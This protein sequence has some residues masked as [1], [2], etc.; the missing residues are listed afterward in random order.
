[1]WTKGGAI[2]AIFMVVAATRAARRSD[3]QPGYVN[4]DLLVSSQQVADQLAATTVRLIDVRS[5]AHYAAGHLPGAVNLPLAVLTQDR[6]GIPGMVAPVATIEHALGTRGIS[7]QTRVVIYDA[8]G[9]VQATRLFWVLDYLGHPR[10][11]ILQGGY[12][13][14]QR[15]GRPVARET[16]S[17]RVTRYRARKDTTRLANLRWVQAQ[18]Q[19]PDVVLLDSRSPAEFSGQ[20]PG[21]QIARPGH[22]PGAVNVNWV[23]NLTA[24]PRRFKSGEAL[25]QL[26]RDVGVTPDKEIVVYCRTGVRASHAYF[27][28]RLLGYARVRVYDGSFV[29]WSAQATAPVEEGQVLQTKGGSDTQ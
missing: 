10:L 17:P 20:V 16:M 6:E 5:P 22:I 25:R 15:E 24:P 9:G 21:R 2:L 1:M 26:Y 28:L 3:T 27:V 8:F 13:A 29:E 14:W 11:S 12:E 18:L 7:R 23:H 19:T 4:A